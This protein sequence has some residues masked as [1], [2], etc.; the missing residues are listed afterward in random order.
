MKLLPLLLAAGGLALFAWQV[1]PLRVNTDS[2][3]ELA[4]PEADYK[5]LCRNE[6]QIEFEKKGDFRQVAIA[7]A[8]IELAP[9]CERRIIV[10]AKP[11][12]FYGKPL[13]SPN[14]GP[15]CANLFTLVVDVSEISLK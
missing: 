15:D 8:P 3:P 6:Y 9:L 11:R 2:M 4:D 14:A 12:F 1:A 5:L 13:C 7:S 10:K